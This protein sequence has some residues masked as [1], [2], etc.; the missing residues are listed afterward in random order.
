MVN[1]SMSRVCELLAGCS[2]SN[3]QCITTA[4]TAFGLCLSVLLFQSY[5]RLGESPKSK[6][7]GFIEQGFLQLQLPRQQ[8][9]SKSKSNM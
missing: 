9:Q 6:P 7:L 8:C 4:T 3:G 1:K 2:Q 5:F